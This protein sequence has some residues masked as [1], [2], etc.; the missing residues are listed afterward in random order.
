MAAS[1][2]DRGFVPVA[3][4]LCPVPRRRSCLGDWPWSG[5]GRHSLIG[6][7]DMR[8]RTF[9]KTFQFQPVII[10]NREQPGTISTKRCERKDAHQRK[11]R[12]DGD[13]SFCNAWDPLFFR[14]KHTHIT[15]RLGS[16]HTQGC[17]TEWGDCPWVRVVMYTTV[18]AERAHT[19]GQR[20]DS[21]P[22]PKGHNKPTHSGLSCLIGIC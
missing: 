9:G 11:P 20:R 1:T 15:R 8:A 22:N 7:M 13:G 6:I 17:R 14:R 5:E 19:H 12:A 3:G 10:G 16:R 21:R 4:V 2:G 18:A